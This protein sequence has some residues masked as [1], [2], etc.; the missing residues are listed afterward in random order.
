MSSTDSK[1]RPYEVW[2]CDRQTRKAVVASS[3]M[4]LRERGGEKLG[5]S[6]KPPLRVVLESDGTEV[7]DENYFQTVEKD[8]V[9]L[10]L[11]PSENWLPTSVETLRAA[12]RAIPKIV[13]E[14]INILELVDQQ[15]A[16]KIMD[17]KDQV[18][19]VLHWDQ[20]DLQSAA[21]PKYCR[22][23]E[24]VSQEG[25]ASASFDDLPLAGKTHATFTLGS[26]GLKS[27]VCMLPEKQEG[28]NGNI[29][30]CDNSLCDFHCSAFHKRSA[31]IILN[32]SVA[33]SPI[34]EESEGTEASSS[35]VIT[36]KKGHFLDE[37]QEVK[38][39]AH[40][41]YES[42]TE[43]VADEELS[44][45][46]LLLTDQLSLTQ[47]KHLDIK[48]IG[49]ILNHLN[50]KIVEVQKLEREKESAEIHNWTIKATI[51]GEVVREIG[52]IY[53]GQYYGIMEHPEH[54]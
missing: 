18:S 32:K 44:E 4:E 40:D 7:E 33:T 48:D 46:Y 23:V 11:A 13:C 6:L 17:S 39:R 14:A 24:V 3:L 53:N 50:S 5:Y 52:V 41:E 9:F 26:L 1:N 12:I 2:S 19:V 27:A 38:N 15:P 35:E 51:R 37:P 34:Q 42:H 25:Q 31:H 16:W 29:S 28:E 54:F 45:H 36:H 8:T 10:L 30:D 21:D 22:S 20:L 43:N 47:N 49:V